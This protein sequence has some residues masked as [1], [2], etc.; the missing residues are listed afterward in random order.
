MNWKVLLKN[1]FAR[2]QNFVCT[3][4]Y[5]M[6]TLFTFKKEMNTFFFKYIAILLIVA[7]SAYSCTKKESHQEFSCIEK[8]FYDFPACSGDKKGLPQEICDS[9]DELYYY[10]DG[11]KIYL[12]DWLLNDWLVVGFD[13]Q[14]K[15]NEIV[16]YINQTGLF[17]PV[18][19]CHIRRMPSDYHQLS[20]DERNYAR[21]YVNT[22][23]PKTCTQLK[24]TIKALEETPIVAFANLVFCWKNHLISF[25]PY[26]FV[27]VK[28]GKDVL[29]E[30]HTVI[31]ETNTILVKNTEIA[32]LPGYEIFEKYT[33]TVNN[34][35][36]GNALQMANYFYET[37]YFDMVDTDWYGTNLTGTVIG[38]NT[39]TLFSFIVQVDEKYPIGEPLPYEFNDIKKDTP[40][41]IQVQYLLPY[42]QHSK[43][44]NKKISFTY[45]PFCME[46][47]DLFHPHLGLGCLGLSNV[48][49]VIID[50]QIF[51]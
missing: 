15:D 30:L 43:I 50:Y 17:K 51:N 21:I 48:M 27:Y 22:N 1:H 32:K 24:E 31:Q 42:H 28:T 47:A 35:S 29:S 5:S 13:S 18:D 38:T 3:A 41:V 20:S 10:V 4:L 11:E 19:I 34:N 9:E 25:M 45:R 33:L 23:D 12:Q 40:N 16:D 26:F 49:Y 46:D 8:L 36:K 37:G 14:I 44:M 6:C 7:G 2:L 39:C